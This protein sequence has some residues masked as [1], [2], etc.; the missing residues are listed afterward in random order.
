MYSP[1]FTISGKTSCLSL[2]YNGDNSYLFI[3]GEQVV[4]FRSQDFRLRH[5]IQCV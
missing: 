2:H 4:N 3:N 5:D 1:N